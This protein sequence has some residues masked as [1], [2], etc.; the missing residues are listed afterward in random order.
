MKAILKKDLHIHNQKGTKMVIKAGTQL[1]FLMRSKSL[2]W[3]MLDKNMIFIP[4]EK[5]A[6][7][8]STEG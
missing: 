6:E 7:F 4:C 2:Y 5:L 3:F 1:K 8:F